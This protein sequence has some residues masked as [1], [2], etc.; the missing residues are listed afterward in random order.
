MAHVEAELVSCTNEGAGKVRV[1][2]SL[3][4]AA[5]ERW[6]AELGTKKPA[7]LKDLRATPDTLT[8]DVYA[9]VAER[10]I[11]Q[12]HQLVK[13]VNDHLRGDLPKKGFQHQTIDANALAKDILSKYKGK[14]F[15]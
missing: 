5:D 9:D 11:E 8:I 4:P 12:V 1:S 10:R 15:G 14:R 6:H 13:S 7:D 3:Q 2:W